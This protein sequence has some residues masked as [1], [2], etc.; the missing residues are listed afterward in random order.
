MLVLSFVDMQIYLIQ[1][2]LQLEKSQPSITPK[3][4]PIQ[5]RCA[6]ESQSIE[7]VMDTVV[8]ELGKVWLSQPRP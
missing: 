5:D 8:Q 4:Q 6:P 2:A 1:A 7:Q 3:P